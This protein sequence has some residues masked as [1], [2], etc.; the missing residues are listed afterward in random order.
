MADETTTNT[1]T[2][3]KTYAA[4]QAISGVATDGGRKDLIAGDVIPKCDPKVLADLIK[5]GLVVEV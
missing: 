5:R 4:K 2:G 3:S 1:K